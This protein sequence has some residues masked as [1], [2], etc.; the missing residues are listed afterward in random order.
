MLGGNGRKHKNPIVPLW[1][2]YTRNFARPYPFP[3]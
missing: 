1:Y 3:K 2:K